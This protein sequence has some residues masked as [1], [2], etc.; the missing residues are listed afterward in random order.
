MCSGDAAFVAALASWLL[1]FVFLVGALQGSHRPQ[2]MDPRSLLVPASPDLH[3]FVSSPPPSSS[4]DS[5]TKA[6]PRV[7]TAA[8]IEDTESFKSSPPAEPSP[9][10]SRSST[11]GS[12]TS[13]SAHVSITPPSSPQQ[14]PTAPGPPPHVVDSGLPIDWEAVIPAWRNATASLPPI[15]IPDVAS[16]PFLR[17]VSNHLPS[18]PEGARC[19]ATWVG[20]FVLSPLLGPL[21]VPCAALFVVWGIF[22][23][24][25]LLASFIAAACVSVGAPHVAL[26]IP[27]TLFRCTL[28]V[29]SSQFG[30]MFSA[31]LG[32]LAGLYGMYHYGCMACNACACH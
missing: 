20:V 21:L 5:A 11:D 3:P 23:P 10:P 4:I 28:S 12:P 30:L 17:N 9:A 16:I 32:E 22:G 6:E 29:L 15:Q 7:V 18:V 14:P 8:P 19:A 27:A 31:L 2:V 13:G 1:L 24:K 25:G 26:Q